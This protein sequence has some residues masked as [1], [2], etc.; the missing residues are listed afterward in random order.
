V[1]PKALMNANR[2]DIAAKTLYGRH[3]LKNVEGSFGEELYLQHLRVWNNLIEKEPNKKGCQD[4]LNSYK[5]L[6]DNIN[7]N[8]FQEEVSKVPIH[9]SSPLNG[10][11]RIASCIVLDK[12]I[13]TY[14]GELIEGQ[15]V[16]DY[17][18]LKYKRNFVS[19][20]LDELFLDEMALEF[21]RIKDNVYTI[22][23]FPSHHFPI[24]ALVHMIKEKYGIIYRK[25]IILTNTGMFNYIHNLYYGESWIGS[26]ESNY[27]GVSAKASL[28][29]SLGNVAEVLLI[30]ENNVEELFKFKQEL[31]SHCGV[32]NHSVHINDTQEETWRIASSVFNR[33]SIDYMN[34]KQFHHTPR[35]DS[36]FDSYRDI[37]SQY[38]DKEDFCV[39]SSAVLSAY[40]L[41]DCRD[42]DFLHL[43]DVEDLAPMIECHNAE[44][45]HYR[46]PKND[47]IFNPRNH[48]Y[49]HGLK[50][51]SLEV[52]RKM[53]EYRDEEKDRRDISLIGEVK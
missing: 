33:N 12:E 3:Y 18:Y 8:G 39:D 30:E 1:K 43:R 2:F 27:P 31:R 51:A 50:F 46:L 14:E 36:Y 15:P 48:F 6:L 13:S 7:K 4:F 35:F 11:H 49:R 21:C 42:L 5:T 24:D 28:C 26:K 25:R 37:L 44:S 53:K 9:N 10:A 22:T 16:C 23:L 34:K 32:S 20:G 47:I 19:S 38:S 40:G 45:R 29:F 17:K 41:R 52:V